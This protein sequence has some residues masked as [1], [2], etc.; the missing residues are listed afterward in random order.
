MS[1][2]ADKSAGREKRIAVV[3][4]GI[5]GLTAAYIL[6]RAGGVTVYEASRRL[7][8]HAHARHFD[9]ANGGRVAIDTGFITFSH[10]SYPNLSRLFTELDVDTDPTWLSFAIRCDGCGLEYVLA[11]GVKGLRPRVVPADRARYLTMLAQV[12]RFNQKARKLA[13]QGVE[14]ASPTL[15]EFLAAGHFTDYFVQHYVIPLVSALWSCGPQLVLA[16]PAPYVVR[17]LA[18]HGLLDIYKSNDWR[19]VRGTSQSYVDRIA[20]ILIDVRLS[21]PVKCVRRT[22]VGV[23]ITD[24]K[25]RTETYD[26][27][28]MATHADQSLRLLSDATEA[29]RRVLGAF[30]YARNTVTIHTDTSI[31]SGRPGARG[32]WNYRLVACSPPSGLALITYHMNKLH[33]FKAAEEYFV[34]LNDAAL[35][36]RDRV[37]GEITYEHPIDTPA[38]V[39]ARQL[40]PALSTARTAFAGAYHGWSSHEDG[41]RSGV[42]AALAL[43]VRW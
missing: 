37:V 1:G 3:G 12:P 36:D 13:R 27:V 38:S 22:P 39:A 19:T 16:Y 35:V 43:G 4:A 29:E 41:C 40:L 11:D 8:G 2:R 30:T 42:D 15:G 21:T 25:G 26:A 24:A 9:E 33:R 17:Y 10:K 23:E 28:V 14:K 32:A 20:R 31:L 18:H 5:S 6:Q 7:G 34:T